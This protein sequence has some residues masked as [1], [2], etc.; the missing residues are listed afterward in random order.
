MISICKTPCR[1]SLFGGGTDYEKF[2]D[3]HGE[4]NVINF[5]INKY[6]YTVA[7]ENIDNF[8]IYKEKYR[9]NYYNSEISKNINQIKNKIIKSVL[10]NLK[11]SEPYYISLFSDVASGTGLG[12]SSAFIVN[13][14][15]LFCKLKKINMSDSKIFNLAI[16]I[17]RE[18]INPHVGLQDHASATFGGFNHF[19]FK[20]KNI[21]V[22]NLNNYK[23][24]LNYI[25]KNSLLIWT[26]LSRDSKKILKNQKKN[27]KK[28]YR[29]LK[30]IN[31]IVFTGIDEIRKKN[32]NLQ[33]FGKIVTESFYLKNNL[34]N[35]ITNSKMNDILK[36]VKNNNSYGYKILGAGGGGFVFC[37]VNRVQKKNIIEKI[38]K[39]N[40]N[41]VVDVQFEAGS[42]KIGEF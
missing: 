10:I 2:I 28:N 31:N 14:L 5:T 13:L 25:L 12:S 16:K 11:I 40:R 27:Y 32:I 9:L 39:S 18:T 41:A 15:R 36:L 7:K 4:S 29:Y 33:Y 35:L 26:G 17:E 3:F 8:N 20:K 30:N 34:S 22:N 38:R 24:N 23:K 19:V 37:I 6:V 42:S 21:Q 1:I